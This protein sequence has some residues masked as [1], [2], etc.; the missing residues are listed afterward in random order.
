M[1]RQSTH[2]PA[3]TARAVP[4]LLTRPMAQSQAFA[5]ALQ[6]RFGDRLRPIVTPLMA[7]VFLTPTLPNRP[8]AA[9]SFTSA[10]G[11]AAARSL[12]LPRRAWCVGAQTAARARAAGFE[13]L[14]A[15][16]DAAALVAAILA[17][18]P[19][20][21]LLH[22]RGEE[23]R[24]DVADMLNSAGLETFSAIVY[25][26][27][28]QPL[29]VAARAV[30]AASGPVI[31][32]IFSPRTGTLFRQALPED[33]RADLRFAMMSGAVS[34]ALAGVAGT[35]AIARRPDADAMLDA[36]ARLLEMRPAP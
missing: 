5:S 27:D 2:G 10:T 17:D 26:Q 19:P 15:D 14:S 8:F 23:V 12:D 28:P 11:V 22:L 24:G 35:V 32:P 29:T 20:G 18:P 3:I 6:A 7:P 4:V 25:R 9:V 13:A 16:G 33:L 21:R 30:L 1:A 36:V 31:V 34:D